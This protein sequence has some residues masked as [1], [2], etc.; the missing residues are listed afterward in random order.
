MEYIVKNGYSVANKGWVIIQEV[1]HYV[2]NGFV[3]CDSGLNN[4]AWNVTERKSI[5]SYCEI[6]K[7]KEEGQL[8]IKF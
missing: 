8:S 2:L 6:H 1:E 4:R 7:G 5:C 3:W